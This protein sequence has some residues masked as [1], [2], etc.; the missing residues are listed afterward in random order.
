MIEGKFF[1]V[2]IE[3]DRKM[4]NLVKRAKIVLRL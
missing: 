4:N 3:N 2:D 1:E